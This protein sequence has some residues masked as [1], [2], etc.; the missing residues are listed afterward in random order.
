MKKILLVIFVLFIL[1]SSA[2]STVAQ[3]PILCKPNEVIQLDGQCILQT[4]QISVYVP[5][6]LGPV[7][8][9]RGQ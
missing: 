5:I 8:Q 9:P 3:A 2:F 6:I 7:Q 4:L 1:F